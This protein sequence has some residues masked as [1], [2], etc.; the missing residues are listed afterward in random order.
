MVFLPK[1]FEFVVDP[2]DEFDIDGEEE[3]EEVEEDGPKTKLDEGEDALDDD[4]DVGPF[5]FTHPGA[6]VVVVGDNENDEEED[7]LDGL[8][9]TPSPTPD[10]LSNGTTTTTSCLRNSQCDTTYE[11]CEYELGVC[12]RKSGV[13]VCSV[14]PE[15]CADVYE[16]VW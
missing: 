14:M 15:M 16:P 3:E 10:P 13:G 6:G 2:V 11:F 1:E 9:T 12:D 7:V 5:G 8:D 4:L